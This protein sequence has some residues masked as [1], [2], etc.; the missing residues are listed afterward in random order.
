MIN[1][2]LRKKIITSGIRAEVTTISSS[3][4][5]S[6]TNTIILQKLKGM[7]ETRQKELEGYS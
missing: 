4:V 1:S 2:F 6:E 3:P 7:L 5:I